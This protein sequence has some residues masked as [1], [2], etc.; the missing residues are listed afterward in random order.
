M[1]FVIICILNLIGSGINFSLKW[2]RVSFNFNEVIFFKIG[3][4]ESNYLPVY[5][6]GNKHAV[7][8]LKTS[9][10]MPVR[11]AADSGFL[12]FVPNCVGM[13]MCTAFVVLHI[14]V[15]LLD[16]RGI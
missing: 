3:H 1:K 11:M 8:I 14:A 16:L 9:S 7:Y 4:F 13:Y 6:W 2:A 15:M 10:S 5:F 12:L